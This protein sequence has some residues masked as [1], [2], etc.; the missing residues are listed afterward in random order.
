M[1]TLGLDAGGSATRWALLDVARDSVVARGEAGPA[2][3]HI[4]DPAVRAR[5]LAA[6]DA[7]IAAVRPHGAPAAIAGGVTGLGAGTPEAAE[8]AALLANGLGTPLAAVTLGERPVDP[9]A[10]AVSRRR[11]RHRLCGHGLHCYGIDGQGRTVKIGGYGVAIDDAGSAYWIAARGLRALLR[12]RGGGARRGA[13][14]GGARR[15]DRRQRLAHDPAPASTDA[16]AAALRRWRPSSR[17]AHE[18]DLDALDILEEAAAELA[19]LGSSCRTDAMHPHRWPRRRLP[20]ASAAGRAHGVSP[21]TGPDL[22]PA[23]NWTRRWPR[24]VYLQ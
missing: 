7:V 18:G 17:A 16:T 20:A 11:R 23:S 22:L 5:T 12:R 8:L 10:R 4:F 6:W 13:A 14:G 15:P 9:G 3:G 19:R 2:S 1:L 21:R 24:R